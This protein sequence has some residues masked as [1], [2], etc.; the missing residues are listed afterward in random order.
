MDD[1]Q[2][3]LSRRAGAFTLIEILIVVVILGIVAAMVVPNITLASEEAEQAA[4]IS[5][6]R[7]FAQAAEICTAFTGDYLE[8]S[9]SGELPTGWEP[10]VDEQ[11]WT[12]GTP[13]GGVWDVE[14]NSFGF[15]SGFGVHFN[16]GS[17][18]GDEY[19]LDVDTALDDGNLTTGRF[20][21]VADDRYYY[22][23]VN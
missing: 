23:L 14:L 21:K 11:N 2:A 19:M 3:R 20:Q 9:S 15:T 10:Y 16:T 12:G 7:S 18:P 4:F 6:I 17:N 1:R 13:V 5:N 8:D 22:I